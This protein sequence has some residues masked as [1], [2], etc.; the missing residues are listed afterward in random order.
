LSLALSF[1]TGSP[2]STLSS[3]SSAWAMDDTIVA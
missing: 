2:D 1:G 3:F